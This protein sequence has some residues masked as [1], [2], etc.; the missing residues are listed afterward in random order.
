MTFLKHSITIIAFVLFV[1]VTQSTSD[2]EGVSWDEKKQLWKVEVFFNGKKSK[3][4]FENKLDAAKEINQVCGYMKI[5]LKNLELLDIPNQQTKQQ[6]SKHKGVSWNKR[7][8]HWHAYLQPNSR[9]QTF[10]GSFKNELDAAKRVNQLYEELKIPPPNPGIV[11]IP[12]QRLP[13][14]VKTSQYKGVSWQ[15][16][17]CKWFA[18]LCLKGEQKHGGSFINE[19][20]AA[21]RVNQLCK[22]FGIPLQNL[23]IAAIPTQPQSTK[24]KTSQYE[25]VNWNKTNRK[26]FARLSSKGKIQKYG[27]CFN[28]ELDAAKRVN[29]MCEEMKIP[30]RNSGISAIPTQQC[31][32]KEKISQYEGVSW[33]SQRYKWYARLRLKYQIPKY[34]GCFNSE[35]DAARRVNQM[36][37]EMKIPLRNSGIS[38]IPTQR[39]QK[40]TREASI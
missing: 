32:K 35:L 19:M 40:K 22:Q 16:K 13:V 39:R 12:N 18:H 34:G 4:Y 5:P 3:L 28:D 24:E 37:E 21:K 33:H 9:T 38:T 27:G 15:K 14:K 17:G 25:G 20:D 2:Y 23:G 31:Q 36:C 11:G 1:I 30:L 26:W 8:G 10:G 6:T 29:Q 7:S